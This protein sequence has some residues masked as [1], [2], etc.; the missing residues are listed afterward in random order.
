MKAI[1]PRVFKRKY[2]DNCHDR[3]A[4]MVIHS[5][6]GDCYADCCNECYDKRPIGWEVRNDEDQD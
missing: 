1:K 3:L 6:D 5:D 2:C 4:T